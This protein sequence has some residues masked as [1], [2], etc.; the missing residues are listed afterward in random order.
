MSKK[1]ASPRGLTWTQA[2]RGPGADTE[3]QMLQLFPW[4]EKGT[5]T[6]DPIMA[7]EEQQHFFLCKPTENGKR[8]SKTS[9]DL[10]SSKELRQVIIISFSSVPPEGPNQG[11]QASSVLI[12]S[13][14]TLSTGAQ[15]V[16]I[17]PC[18]VPRVCHAYT[19]TCAEGHY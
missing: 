17:Q 1:A 5:P 9:N 18:R 2:F 14:Q 8:W 11:R 3:L 15:D 6:P 10:Q 19:V 13:R 12:W 16:R 4:L 7:S